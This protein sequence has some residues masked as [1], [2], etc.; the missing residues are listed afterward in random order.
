[1]RWMAVD[2]EEYWMS[3]ASEKRNEKLPKTV[4]I[5]IALKGIEPKSTSRCYGG[6]GADLL[7]LAASRNHRR[8][9]TQT[10]SPGQ[11]HIRTNPRFI[12]KE[13][14]RS[15]G[16]RTRSEHRKL[17]PLPSFDCL[18]ISLVGSAQRLLWSDVQFREKSPYRSHS[19]SN[20][21]AHRD[22]LTDN[23]PRPQTE[24]ETILPWIFPDDPSSDLQLL[25]RT[26]QGRSAPRLG[27]S[28]C[29]LA[30]MSCLPQP[31]VDRRAAK[32]V[33]LDHYTCRLTI[34]HAANR[35]LANGF[36]RFVRQRPPIDSDDDHN[37]MK[38]CICVA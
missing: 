26:Q 36:A 29:S 34:P 18:R 3:S 15:N 6:D 19:K 30:A 7:P 38:R 13:H 17:F 4:R 24:I 10:P 35:H 1:M 16:S 20:V 27:R 37:N 33:A 11:R 23:L 25:P 21:Q 9:T 8:S 32:P 12:E 31:L 14:I 22:Q 5:Q 2:N 28:Q